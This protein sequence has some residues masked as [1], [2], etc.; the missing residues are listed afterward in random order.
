MLFGPRALSLA[1]AQLCLVRPM[2]RAVIFAAFCVVAFLAAAVELNTDYITPPFTFSPDHRYGVMIPVFHIEAAQEPDE[3]MNK[4]VELGAHNIVSV[5]HAEPG[6]DRALNHH[7]TAPP[8]WSPDSSLLL[9]KVDGK[10]NPDAGALSRLRH[11]IDR[12]PAKFKRPLQETKFSII[13]RGA[14]LG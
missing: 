3:R 4:V 7:E 5:I 2:Q 9:W 6:Y 11:A 10:W 8:R 12:R 13:R 1:A 14:R